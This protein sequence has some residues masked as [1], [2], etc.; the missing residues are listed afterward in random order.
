MEIVVNTI[1]KNKVSGYLSI[2]KV[3]QT[4]ASASSSGSK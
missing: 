3:N 4:V 2:P 1:D